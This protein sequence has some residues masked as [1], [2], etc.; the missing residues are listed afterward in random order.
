MFFCCQRLVTSVS[1]GSSTELVFWQASS[2]RGHLA[3]WVSNHDS[4]HRHVY[5]EGEGDIRDVRDVVT[6]FAE[7]CACARICFESHE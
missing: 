6:S 3:S 1:A 2:R 7:T 4:I 5:G